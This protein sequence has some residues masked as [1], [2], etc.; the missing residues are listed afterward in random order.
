[1]SPRLILIQIYSPGFRRIS[2]LNFPVSIF[3]L[4]LQF[5]KGEIFQLHGSGAISL[6]QI[7]NLNAIIII[8]TEKK[9][10]LLIFEVN[11]GHRA[12]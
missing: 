6:R 12:I 4:Q 9:G 8:K 5:A 7:S 2:I 3:V 11:V 1:M 10:F